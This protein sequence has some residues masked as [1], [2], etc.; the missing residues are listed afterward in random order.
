MMSFESGAASTRRC[1]WKIG[2]LEETAPELLSHG[3]GRAAPAA[4]T[5]KP[6]G[7]PRPH[8]TAR[9]LTGVL[10]M[11]DWCLRKESPQALAAGLSL[12]FAEL[13]QI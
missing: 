7:A 9:R 11:Q 2:F 13:P 1:K 8:C 10:L 4:Y 3:A 6:P 12:I 5:N